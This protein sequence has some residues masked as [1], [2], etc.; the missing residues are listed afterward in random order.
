[1]KFVVIERVRVRTIAVRGTDSCH[2]A[3]LQNKKQT[4]DV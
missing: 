1:M 4:F 2:L 3:G